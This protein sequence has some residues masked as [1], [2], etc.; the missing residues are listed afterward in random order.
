MVLYLQEISGDDLQVETFQVGSIASDA[1]ITALLY[2]EGKLF[3]GSADR[4]IKVCYTFFSSLFHK[5]LFM[6]FF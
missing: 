3:V 4:I 6:I 5:K 1:V 2:W